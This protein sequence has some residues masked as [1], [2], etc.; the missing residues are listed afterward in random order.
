[1]RMTDLFVSRDLSQ[2]SEEVAKGPGS[3]LGLR[4]WRL[5][6][7]DGNARELFILPRGVKWEGRPSV[8]ILALT[9]M[10]AF[11]PGQRREAVKAATQG[12]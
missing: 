10:E 11:P 12:R 9:E 4:T 5:R 3:Q 6:Y 2:L 7:P 1:M 8:L